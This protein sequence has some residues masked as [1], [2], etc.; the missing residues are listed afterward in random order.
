MEHQFLKVR[1]LRPGGGGEPRHS[2]TVVVMEAN[3]AREL[4]KGAVQGTPA[5]GEVG[6]LTFSSRSFQPF[7]VFPEGGASPN[8][9]RA[10][11]LSEAP[12]SALP[13][14]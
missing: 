4:G 7:R 10:S 8:R 13:R 11:I 3:E 1:G 14:G 2:E 9:R 12:V 6:S 5:K